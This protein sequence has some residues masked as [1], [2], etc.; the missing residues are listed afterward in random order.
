MATLYLVRHGE[1]DWN[2][3]RRLQGQTDIPL[4][5]AGRAQARCLA[6]RLAAV[7]FH[8][9]YSS[10]SAR[11]RETAEIVLTGRSL[12]PEALVGLRERSYGRWEGLRGEE[13]VA[14]DPD[15]WAI[16]QRRERNLAPH[17]GESDVAVERRIHDALTGIAERHPASSVLVVSHGGVVSRILS[18][19][20]DTP[21]RVP[22]NCEVNVLEIVG[23]QRRLVERFTAAALPLD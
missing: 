12:I 22:A 16:W 6:A 3:D 18:I 11:A 7:H 20:L 4:N 17:G 23:N 1:T 15:N 10:D 2:R 19:W 9:A 14:Q 5:E 8:A 21:A 13:I